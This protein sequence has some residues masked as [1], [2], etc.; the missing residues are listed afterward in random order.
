MN[1]NAPARE[2]GNA[3]SYMKHGQVNSALQEWGRYEDNPMPCQSAD[4]EIEDNGFPSSMP[5]ENHSIYEPIDSKELEDVVAYQTD[6][7]DWRAY[8]QFARDVYGPRAKRIVVTRAWTIA[9]PSVGRINGICNIAVSLE[10]AI[11]DQDGLLL[12]PDLTTPCWRN[13]LLQPELVIA[14]GPDYSALIIHFLRARC[15]TIS[16]AIPS[17]TEYWIDRSPLRH[18]PSLFVPSDLPF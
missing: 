12:P 13:W 15:P 18:G 3:M 17:V 2:R 14:P 16:A 7:R 5:E 10:V 11:Y 1:E 4:G 9:D 6:L 8:S